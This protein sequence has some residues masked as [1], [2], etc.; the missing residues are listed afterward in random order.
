[1]V[2]KLNQKLR[3]MSLIL[4]GLGL[5]DAAYLTWVKFAD[6]PVVCIQGL[7]NC[8]TVNQSVYSVWNGVP[9]ALIGALAYLVML[10][11]LVFEDK[12]EF[13]IDNGRIFILGLSLIGFLYSIY[14]TYLE[15]AVIKAICPYCVGSATMMTLILVMTII[16]LVPVRQEA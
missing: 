7:G 1:M 15:I 2:K 3:G 12:N 14:L 6:K 9:I 10:G 4:A 16:R 8:N 11:I 13:L 5:M